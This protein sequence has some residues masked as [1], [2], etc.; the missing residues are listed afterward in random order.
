MKVG[1][2]WS[3]FFLE[4]RW[5]K[6]IRNTPFPKGETKWRVESVERGKGS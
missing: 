2:D 3:L 4:M 5:G 6:E 1:V